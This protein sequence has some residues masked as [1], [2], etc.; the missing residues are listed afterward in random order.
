MPNIRHMSQ[1]LNR[2]SNAVVRMRRPD[3]ILGE[4]CRI[5]VNTGGFL[6]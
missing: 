3:A 2:V 1:V 4:A 5:A 6:M